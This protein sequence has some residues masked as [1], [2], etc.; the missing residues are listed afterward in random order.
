MKKVNNKLL[1]LLGFAA[2]AGKLSYGM[3]MSQLAV[4]TGKSFLVV[5]AFDVSEKSKK[6]ISFH[7]NNKNVPFIVLDDVNIETVGKA[8]GRKCGILSVNDESFAEAIKG[9]YANDQ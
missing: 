8:V 7:T 9:G 3:D 6:E 5:C 2:K 4:K 1:T